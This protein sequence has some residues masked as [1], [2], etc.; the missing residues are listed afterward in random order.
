VRYFDIP[1]NN[2]DVY[3]V[4]INH[5]QVTHKTIQPEIDTLSTDAKTKILLI[6]NSMGSHRYIF[7]TQTLLV[8]SLYNLVLAGYHPFR[9][10]G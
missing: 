5:Q 9:V 7:V 2:D 1:Q 10:G 4:F 3:K 8:K 6:L